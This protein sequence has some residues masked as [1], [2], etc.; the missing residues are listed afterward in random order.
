MTIRGWIASSFSSYYARTRN[1][2]WTAAS[3]LFLACALSYTRAQAGVTVGADAEYP[4]RDAREVIIALR[5]ATPAAQ[6]AAKAVLERADPA[7]IEELLRYG[8]T[9]GQREM[10]QKVVVLMGSKAVPALLDLLKSPELRNRAGAALFQAAGPR[11]ADQTPALLACLHD[12]A[13]NNY[14]GTTL[15]K[16]MGPK[17]SDRVPS[18]AEALKDADKTVRLYA[19][20][21]LGQIGPKAKSAVGGLIALLKDPE[22]EV[23]FNA[24]VALGK[25]G[26]G[27]KE[28][29]PALKTMA[30]GQSDAIKIAIK[31]A[32]KKIH[33]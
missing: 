28:A 31:E 6:K 19:A 26:A 12:P 1:S 10:G 11:S 8:R 17:S 29:A 14:C 27:A 25:I 5:T 3:M 18:L 13:V 2:A 21:A 32:L 22:P 20:A 33:G 4:V 23:R 9:P 15:V 24:V 30:P 7:M 16:V